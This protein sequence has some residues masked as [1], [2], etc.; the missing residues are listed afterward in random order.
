MKKNIGWFLLL[1]ALFVAMLFNASVRPVSAQ[2]DIA[3][4]TAPSNDLIGQLLNKRGRLIPAEEIKASKA[5]TGGKAPEQIIDSESFIDLYETLDWTAGAFSKFEYLHYQYDIYVRRPLNQDTLIPITQ[6]WDVDEMYPR[7]SRDSN[8]VIYVSDE[9]GN[10]E[11]YLVS[12]DGGQRYNL[13]NDGADDYAPVWSSDNQWIAYVRETNGLPQ[14][15]M[16]DSTGANKYQLTQCSYGC[17]QPSFS[18]DGMQIL[19]VRVDDPD[20]GD[21]SIMVSDRAGIA[22]RLPLNP[23]VFPFPATPSWSPNGEM[24]AFSY[25]S[26]DPWDI[27]VAVIDMN[28]TVL[29]D[30]SYYSKYGQPYYLID[31]LINGWS[32][33]SKYV[34]T[35]MVL[36]YYYWGYLE[37][38]QSGV[39]MT[40]ALGSPNPDFYDDTFGLGGNFDPDLRSVDIQPPRTSLFLNNFSRYQT[41]LGWY[42]DQ[43]GLARVVDFQIQSRESG[44]GTWQ[45]VPNPTGDISDWMPNFTFSLPTGEIGTKREFRARAKDIA[46]Q[47]EEYPL[48]AGGG[49]ASKQ[50]TFYNWNIEGNLL[51]NRNQPINNQMI[52]FDTKPVLGEVSGEDGHFHTLIGNPAIYRLDVSREGYADIPATSFEANQDYAYDVY[53]QPASNLIV[54]G[55]FE[56]GGLEGWTVGGNLPVQTTTKRFHSGSNS[57]VL[58]EECDFFCLTEPEAVFQHWPNYP[59]LTYDKQ[60]TLY[61]V[62]YTDTGRG[63]QYRLADGGWSQPIVIDELQDVVKFTVSPTGR[64]Y[65][66][67]QQADKNIY[68]YYRDPDGSWSPKFLI[69]SLV[70]EYRFYSSDIKADDENNLHFILYSN[71]PMLYYKYEIENGTFTATE[72]GNMSLQYVSP[73]K[74]ALLPDNRAIVVRNDSIGLVSIIQKPDGTFSAPA[75]MQIEKPLSRYFHLVS[76]TSGYPILVWAKSVSNDYQ[77]FVQFMDTQENWSA[78]ILIYSGML[79]TSL[80]DVTACP[81]G[82]LLISTVMNNSIIHWSPDGNVENYA[83]P[84]NL[85]FFSHLHCDID[86]FLV[87]ENKIMFDNWKGVVVYEGKGSGPAETADVSQQVSIPADLHQPTLSFAFQLANIRRSQQ[88]AL[89]VLVRDQNSIETSLLFLRGSNAWQQKWADLSPWAGQTVTIIFRLNQAANEPTGQA[90]LDGIA[91]GGWTTP[92]ITSIEPNQFI[93]LDQ[94]PVLTVNGGNYMDGVSLLLNDIPI[95]ADRFTRIDSSTLEII[96]SAEI[97]RG[98]STL[99]VVNPGG[100]SAERQ[101]A[102][103]YLYPLFLPTV[104]RN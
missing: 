35:T 59:T 4:P 76:G 80:E 8:Q 45:N 17:Y 50:T 14:I 29:N 94:V 7:L 19:Y 61:S 55:E 75:Q 85:L 32:P 36:Y 26:F 43:T 42:V 74:L 98:C 28:G 73:P 46:G 40:M 70:S 79:S 3:P 56:S 84:E 99:K 100:A 81:D 10:A 9:T 83:I 25:M 65:A 41:Q 102:I 63:I 86:N 89:E 69:G 93:S 38:A 97:P 60:G 6:T 33:D 24:I 78:P 91:V 2:D 77:L 103:C 87:V 23:N 48:P 88:T 21:S 62:V 51:D 34:A 39:Q 104:G 53:L 67:F 12:V 92:I 20:T 95:P 68:G 15:F 54:N 90:W 31:I 27:R 30:F 96:A 58:G 1:A 18:P 49:E 37:F 101:N 22:Y 66:I 72:L 82:S 11:I 47:W 71:Q 57:M 44:S 16:M 13:T 52:E 5:L 64:Y